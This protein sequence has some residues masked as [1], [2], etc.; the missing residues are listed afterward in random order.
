MRDAICI[1]SP[2]NLASN[3]RVL[4]EADALHE[5]GYAV[6]AVVCDY[7]EALRPFD[8][9]IAA[10][11]PWSVVRVR[12]PAGE[13]QIG[14]AAGQ[15]AR[16]MPQAGI[17]VPVALAARAYGGPVA[18][19]QRAASDLPAD[20]YI[21]H[22]VA[23]L[24]AAAPAARQHGAMLG[25]DAE[26][27][28]AGEGTGG[29]GEAFRMNMVRTIEGALLP[30]CV[31]VTAA[32]PL[33]GDAYARQ[34]GVASSTV[35]NVFPLAMAPAEPA[36]HAQESFK[37]YW[38][39]QTVGLDR[40]L[41]AFIRAMARAKARITLDIR[42][43]DRWGHGDRLM[44]LARELGVADRISLLPVAPPPDM[45][46]LAAPYDIGLSLET[47][48]SENRR[49]CL[50][51]KIFT[52]LLAGV[53]VLLSDTPAQRALAP[54]LGAAARVISLADPD[55]MAVTLDRLASSLAARDE[56]SSTAWRL[57]HERFNWEVEKQ[58]LLSSVARAF[59]ARQVR[60]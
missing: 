49:L 27:F 30:S 15:L 56:A 41:Q 17:K 14:M 42:G 59:R 7:T 46:T 28:H 37:A 12:R 57:G 24:A 10:S 23:G 44:D 3:P 31:H 39:S 45:V 21:A 40:G 51:N 33:I 29:P 9:E 58:A 8:D 55:G 19:L 60:S 16:L 5:A 34:Y 25:F 20:L 18:A 48:V 52:Y 47:D 22:Y 26:D 13:R 50:T 32:A 54:Q 2:G 11:T 53:P 4:K 36:R 6:T 1:V 35:L 38:F 43:G